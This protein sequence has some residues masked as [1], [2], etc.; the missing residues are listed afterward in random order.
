[1][2]LLIQ[3]K[4]MNGTATAL[5]EVSDIHISATPDAPGVLD[6]KG[7]VFIP[8]QRTGLMARIDLKGSEEITIRR[9]TMWFVGTL[10]AVLPV[11]IVIAA[12][13]VGWARDDQTQRMQLQQVQTQAAETRDDVKELNQKFDAVQKMLSDQAVRDAESKGTVKGY[14]L[15][16]TDAGA[17]G[18]KK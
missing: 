2:Q 8:T 15:G 14:Q 18:H 16:Q 10:L 1:M 9:S 5:R 3:E 17:S 12:L 13:L 7:D 11:T 6:A 4:S